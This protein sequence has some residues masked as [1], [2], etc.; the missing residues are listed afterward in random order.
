MQLF[1]SEIFDSI[2]G[3]GS[4]VGKPAIFL[5]LAG[6][7]LRCT[8]CDS[9]FT[10]PFKNK[11]ENEEVLKQIKKYKAK[12]LIITGGEPMLQQTALIPLL[13]E[14]KDYKIEVETNGSVPLKIS[15][16]LEHINCSPKLIS[17]GNKF[18]ELKIKPSNKKAIY[19]FV[20]RDMDDFK[21]LQKYIKVNKL[22]H[23][24]IYLMPEGTRKSVIMERSKWLIEICKKAGYNFSPRLHIMLYDNQ[25]KK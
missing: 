16:Y 2:Q 15:K 14:L 9:K 6:C 11:M 5:R 1:V 13:E 4:T 22:P 18:Y 12:R 17:S 10:W 24:R 7:N 20:V 19:K 3:E 25:R 23:K 8:W 21:E